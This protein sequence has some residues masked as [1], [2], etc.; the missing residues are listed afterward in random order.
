MA[1]LPDTDVLLYKG[2]MSLEEYCN[3]E[4]GGDP[5]YWTGSKWK[6]TITHKL[7]PSSRP[8][9]TNL[10]ESMTDLPLQSTSVQ[11]AGLVSTLYEVTPGCWTDGPP[12]LYNGTYRRIARE[13]P[14]DQ[15]LGGGTWP[16]PDWITPLRNQV[17]DLSIS[18]GQDLAEYRQTANMF[19]D[20][21]T[22][23]HNAYQWFRKKKRA[24]R[25]VNIG[26]IA[27][28]DIVHGFGVRPLVGLLDDSINM[29]LGKL[30]EPT[31][32]K[33]VQNAKATDRISASNSSFKTTGYM[34]TNV[35][36]KVYIK[37]DRAPPAYQFGNAASIIWEI[38]PYSFLIDYMIPVGNYLSAIDALIDVGGVYGTVTTRKQSFKQQVKTVPDQGIF[39]ENNPFRATYQS[40]ER[41]VI[42]SIPQPPFPKWKPS[43]SWH[44]LRHAVALLVMQR[45]R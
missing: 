2:Y 39:L 22:G 12:R 41:E 37:F 24:L 31:H 26:D 34:R 44:K 6:R 18:L 11:E 42:H 23:M 27:A 10:I 13:M 16:A 28:L 7:A 32:V 33:L 8:K 1:Y 25:N 38:I 17:N 30:S 9:P 45:H 43:A 5:S 14:W 4:G 20:A 35:S 15:G 40:H 29:L 36:A 19:H 21:A 3:G